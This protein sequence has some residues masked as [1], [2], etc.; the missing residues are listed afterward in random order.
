MSD[1]M[2]TSNASSAL[3]QAL[4][5]EEQP[6]GNTLPAP[7]TRQLIPRPIASGGDQITTDSDYARENI[8]EL[9]QKGSESLNDAMA[10]AKEAMHPR[11]W[12]VVGQILKV[13]SDNVDKLLKLHADKQKLNGNNSVAAV[14]Q[15]NSGN[16][17]IEQAIIFNGTSDELVR[18]IRK[19]QKSIINGK[20]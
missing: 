16:T 3:A 13:Q 17:N 18:M 14:Q 15:P 12:E 4:G 2:T 20:A 8:I 10:L 11:V 1:T 6:I 7:T 5:L 19:E 9:I